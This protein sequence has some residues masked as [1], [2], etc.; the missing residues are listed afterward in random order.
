LLTIVTGDPPVFSPRHVIVVWPVAG[1]HW[2]V[3][4][5]VPL[6]AAGD[7]APVVATS[8]EVVGDSVDVVGG[9]VDVGAA[10]VVGA[11]VVMVGSVG[12]LASTTP[13]AVHTPIVEASSVAANRT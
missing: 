7:G 13:D 10:V 1:S 3:P 12:E 6:G 2:A 8:A 4:V 9:S 5:S 11:T